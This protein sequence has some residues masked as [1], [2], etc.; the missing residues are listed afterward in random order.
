LKGRVLSTNDEQMT[1]AVGELIGLEFYCS[2]RV[3]LSFKWVG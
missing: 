3:T 2:H 1:Y